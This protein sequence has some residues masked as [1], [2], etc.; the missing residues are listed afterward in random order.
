MVKDSFADAQADQSLAMIVV[1]P[2]YLYSSVATQMNLGT[3]PYV[4]AHAYSDKE[5]PRV[6]RHS[7]FPF[8]GPLVF[9]PSISENNADIHGAK[10]A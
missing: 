9:G 10:S 3:N 2:Y 8:C 4:S 1:Q 5:H 6:F 7:S